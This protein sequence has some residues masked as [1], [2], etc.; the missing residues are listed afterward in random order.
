[1]YLQSVSFFVLLPQQLKR[2]VSPTDCH[3]VFTGCS[4][5]KREERV[6]VL[7]TSI[8]HWRVCAAFMACSNNFLASANRKICPSV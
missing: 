1:M 6:T 4:R 7:K 8:K 2:E 5:K 3:E